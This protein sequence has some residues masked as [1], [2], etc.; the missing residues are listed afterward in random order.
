M[1]LEVVKWLVMLQWQGW[2]WQWSRFHQ[3]FHQPML[4]HLFACC[5]NFIE[6]QF[7]VKKRSCGSRREEDF[8]GFE[9]GSCVLVAG[10]DWQWYRCHWLF[11]LPMLHHSFTFCIDF[12]E[13]QFVRIKLI[14]MTRDCQ[15][16]NCWVCKQVGCCIFLD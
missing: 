5:I 14:I 13:N 16:G 15:G 8:G 3:P 11:H 9:V 6:G 2:V 7:V 1:T 4:H 10:Q 12:I